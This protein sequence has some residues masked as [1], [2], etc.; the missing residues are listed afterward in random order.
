MGDARFEDD[1]WW[2]E[3]VVWGEGYLELPEAACYFLFVSHLV[4]GFT[5]GQG[6]GSERHR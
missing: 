6:K 3:G 5:L 4:I 1:L 2:G